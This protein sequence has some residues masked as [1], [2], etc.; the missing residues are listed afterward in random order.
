MELCCACVQGKMIT[1][2]SIWKLP[3]ELPPML[4]RLHGDICGPINPISGPFRYFLVLINVSNKQ[5]H[6]LLL[7]IRNMVFANLIS[8]LIHFRTHF[9]DYLIKTLHIDNAK[10][11]TS[12]S[13][14]DYCIATGIKL[15][16]CI[17]YEHVQN[18]LA[19][20]FIK[21]IQL[22]T[23]PLLLHANLHASM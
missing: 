14:E 22:I 6:I 15:T 11:F 4:E 1:W 23:R 13:F 18:G 9:L 2:P 21:C 19:E 8:M 12:K 16:Y 10:E 5:S 3:Q 7:S 20:S 17:P